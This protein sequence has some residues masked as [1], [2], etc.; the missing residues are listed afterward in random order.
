M[1]D[2]P[3][4]DSPEVQADTAQAVEAQQTLP[5]VCVVGLGYVGL[6][7][8][9]AFGKERATIGFDIATRKVARLRQFDDVTGEVSR[10]ELQAARFLAITDNAE[11]IRKADFVI[12]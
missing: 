11:E 5:V 8:A 7:V 12:I 6:P 9:V 10:D 1:F 3:V 4:L 2:V